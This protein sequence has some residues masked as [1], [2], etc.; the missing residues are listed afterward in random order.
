MTQWIVQKNMK[1]KMR[2]Y[3]LILY[4]KYNFINYLN[5][6]ST[7]YVICVTYVENYEIIEN[8]VT[9]NLFS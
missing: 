9:P 6:F 2:G 3:D 7:L 8:S 4:Q 1:M 5:L